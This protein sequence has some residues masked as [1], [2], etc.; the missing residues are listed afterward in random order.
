MI[1]I[2]LN[3]D[4][5]HTVC[6][7]RSICVAANGIYFILFY[8]WVIFHCKH[9]PHL[10]YPF[11]CQWTFRLL[12]CLAS[13][14]ASL[15]RTLFSRLPCLTSWDPSSF[16]LNIPFLLSFTLINLFKGSLIAQL[17]KNPPAMQEIWVRSLGWEDLLEKGKATHS[18]VL[19]WR[20]LWTVQSMG[21]QRV[22]YN[23]AT[24]TFKHI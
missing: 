22:R 19:A 14:V 6:P 7:P 20:I 21:L 9:V 2:F 11:I 17:V 10:L 23:W 5:L 13:W 12:P 15:N 16:C 4:L 24:F 18:R 3:S 8:D 1:F